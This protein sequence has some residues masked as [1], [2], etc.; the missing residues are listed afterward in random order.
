MANLRA[1]SDHSA[2]GGFLQISDT[3]TL[4]IGGL[5]C[6][7][8]IDLNGTLSFDGPGTIDTSGNNDL[9][10]NTGTQDVL[11]TAA[12]VDLDTNVSTLAIPAATSLTLGGVAITSANFTAPAIDI[13][14]GD[15]TTNGDPYHTHTDVTAENELTVDGL[16]TATLN[17]YEACYVSANNTV[18][19]TDCSVATG[20]FLTATTAGV[21]NG[22]AGE[23][24]YA[25]KVE[26]QFETGLT[27][28]AGEIANL[29]WTTAGYYT[30]LVPTNG[31]KNFQTKAGII[32]DT[33]LYVNPTWR[34]VMLIQ[35]AK[36][37]LK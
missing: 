34:C 8:S 22:N 31:S 15:G 27:L 20:T 12:N 25:G 7:G 9:T 23:I 36:P 10:I 2:G 17:Q 18:L 28:I 32:L 26:V 13:V 29:S 5:D 14:F 6:A 33:S 30:N 4:L 16:T 1:L 35:P 37:I 24:V 21:Y 11:V 19:A 3:D